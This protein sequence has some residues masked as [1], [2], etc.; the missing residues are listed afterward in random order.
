MAKQSEC[1]HLLKNVQNNKD[2]SVPDPSED[3]NCFTSIQINLKAV[4]IIN[5]SGLIQL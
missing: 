1:S 5:N 4:V 3:S 2:F